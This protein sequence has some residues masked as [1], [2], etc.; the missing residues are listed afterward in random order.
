MLLTVSLERLHCYFD[1]A[2]T[3]A[4]Q[5]LQVEL[6]NGLSGDKPD[7]QAMHSLGITSTSR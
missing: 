3:H 2:A 6:I 4:M 5:R 1:V 7:R